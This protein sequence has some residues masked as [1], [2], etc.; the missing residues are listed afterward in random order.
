MSEIEKEAAEL[1]KDVRKLKAKIDSREAEFTKEME[2]LREK[3]RSKY[4]R[5]NQLA[6]KL[7]TPIN[8]L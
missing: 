8:N 1:L 5:L 3:Y 2:P 4:T 7:R 6:N